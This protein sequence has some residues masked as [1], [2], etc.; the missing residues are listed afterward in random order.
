M[1]E[2]AEQVVGYSTMSGI[3]PMGGVQNVVDGSMERVVVAVEMREEV[4][5]MQMAMQSVGEMVDAVGAVGA[6]VAVAEVA[7]VAVGVVVEVV[8]DKS[9]SEK[10]I[11]DL[12]MV[13]KGEVKRL[14]KIKD[15]R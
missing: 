1:R 3:G 7:A 10:V 6:V 5:Q 9:S 15:G 13:G 12:D 8:V 2:P 14:Y 4:E 11:S